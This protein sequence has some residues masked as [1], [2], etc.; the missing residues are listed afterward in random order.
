V[1]SWITGV[2]IS[3]RSE[4]REMHLWFRGVAK[5]LHLGFMLDFGGRHAAGIFIY[6]FV[7]A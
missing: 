6:V 3:S 5:L 1:I 4:A 2:E 7:K